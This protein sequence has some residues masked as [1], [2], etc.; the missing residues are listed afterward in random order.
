MQTELAGC[1]RSPPWPRVNQVSCLTTERRRYP[2]EN[3][4]RVS[5]KFTGDHNGQR[6]SEINGEEAAKG[7]QG[8]RVCEELRVNHSTRCAALD[9]VASALIS[10][11]CGRE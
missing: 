8:R 2:I 7:A 3:M 4:C 10:V 5:V 1:C 11:R 9:H 6:R